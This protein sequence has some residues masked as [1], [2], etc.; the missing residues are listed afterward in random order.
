M[1]IIL[2]SSSPYRKDLLSKLGIDFKCISPD[3]D[4]S[5]IKMNTS[6]SVEEKAI[7]LSVE[8]AKAIAKDYPECLIIGSDQICHFEDQIF[9]KTL[10]IDKSFELLSFLSGKTHQLTTAYSILKDGKITS[11]CNVTSLKMRDLNSLQIKNYLRKDNPIDCAGSYKLELNG[12]GLFSE[13]KTDD[14]TAI[15]GLPLI[16]LGKDLESFGLSIPG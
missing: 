3:I 2:A 7:K 5:I 1:E 11:H 8:K 14:H 12:I 13:I 15:I 4:E 16:Q 10:N 9:S 6:Y